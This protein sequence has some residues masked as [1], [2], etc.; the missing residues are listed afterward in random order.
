MLGVFDTCLAGHLVVP[1]A[2]V[3]YDC[4][5]IVRH[6]GQLKI[7]LLRLVMYISNLGAQFKIVRCVG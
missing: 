6:V 7:F 4:M 5:A 3:L 2:C 1:F